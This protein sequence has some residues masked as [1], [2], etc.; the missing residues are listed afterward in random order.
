MK[1][2]L[3]LGRF[4][5]IKV[6]VHWTF[7]ILVAWVVFTEYGKGSNTFTTLLTLLYVLAIFACVVLHEFGH[8]LTAGNY[9]IKTK[10]ITLLPIG[11]VAS[12]ERMP[13]KPRQE[14]LVA[15]AG[16]VVNV[17]IA[18]ALFPFIGP[19]QNI[20]SSMQQGSN[21]S[22]TPT[23][24]VFSLVVVNILLVLFNAI[25]AFPM[26]GGRVLRAI[27]AMY[28][29]R[30]K[31]TH[32]AS[33][34]GQGIAVLFFVGGFFF[35]PFLVFIGIFVFFGAYAENMMVQQLEFIK[36]HRIR[37]AMMKNFRT[38]NMD[39]TVGEAVETILSGSDSVFIVTDEE[40]RFA[41]IASLPRILGV[42]KERGKDARIRDYLE[43][44]M[45]NFTPDQKLSTAYYYIQQNRG[46]SCPVI[47]NGRP[48]GLINNAKINEYIMIQSALSY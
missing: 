8:A 14:L 35:N 46:L 15:V 11:G 13:E 12:L 26:D 36:G 23:N 43:T 41:G 27:L 33:R 18:A 25:P 42:L 48:V 28:M 5:G 24:F 22:I 38:I 45:R 40:G 19:V 7:L 20:V 10:Q 2:T 44:G 21:L 31:A 30:V 16:P 39:S 4:F 1:W 37:E 34:L 6:Q 29:D 9:G 3:N 17:A 32:I 47:E